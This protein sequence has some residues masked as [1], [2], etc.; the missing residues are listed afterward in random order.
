MRTTSSVGRTPNCADHDELDDVLIENELALD[1]PARTPTV[2][3]GGELS[4][5]LSMF[6]FPR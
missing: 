4:D 2:A 1:A 6:D 3:D 5:P